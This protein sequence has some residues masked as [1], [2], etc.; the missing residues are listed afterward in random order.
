[1]KLADVR[2]RPICTRAL[3]I[4]HT[5]RRLHIVESIGRSTRGWR[6]TQEHEETILA[7]VER[8]TRYL[9]HLALRQIQQLH[10]QSSQPDRVVI[11]VAI[12]GAAFCL[13]EA[14]RPCRSS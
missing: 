1:M 12:G 14:R 2:C 13:S 5:A 8:N 6:S 3:S 4:G 9:F 11:V 7:K 10:L